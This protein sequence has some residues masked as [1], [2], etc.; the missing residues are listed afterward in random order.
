MKYAWY[1][2]NDHNRPYPSGFHIDIESIE[3]AIREALKCLGNPEHLI[4][5][6]AFGDNSSWDKKSLTIPEIINIINTKNYCQFKS[7]DKQGWSRVET[8]DN[9]NKEEQYLLEAM[10]NFAQEEANKTGKEQT[11]RSLG[12]LSVTVKPKKNK[13][14]T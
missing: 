6:A 12:G 1:S 2:C 5:A 10:G 9:Y 13:K 8:M 3:D 11:A 7:P 14:G 4:G